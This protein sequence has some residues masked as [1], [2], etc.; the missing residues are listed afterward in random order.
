METVDERPRGQ[1]KPEERANGPAR[2]PIPLPPASLRPPPRVPRQAPSPIPETPPA[3]RDDS[4]GRTGARRGFLFGLMLPVLGLGIAGF[5]WWQNRSEGIPASDLQV[6]ARVVQEPQGEAQR[7]L[8]A[9]D[10]APDPAAVAGNPA[11]AGGGE[12]LSIQIASFRTRGRAERVLAEAQARTGLEGLIIP[13]RVDGVRWYRILLG[14]FTA[15]EDA[16]GAAGPLLEDGMITD[17]LVRPVPEQW[18]PA[19]TGREG[20][21]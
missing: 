15:S 14:A 5:L 7:E 6:R 3:V 19:L 18:I 2:R 12:I 20:S 8:T 1:A 16:I 11:V 13:A 17:V 10:P 4:A 21:S 9:P